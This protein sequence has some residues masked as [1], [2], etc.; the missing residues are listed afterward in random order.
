MGTV[1]FSVI[2]EHLHLL[3]ATTEMRRGATN[4]L[5]WLV[6]SAVTQISIGQRPRSRN[7]GAAVVDWGVTSVNTSHYPANER[8]GKRLELLAL[9]QHRNN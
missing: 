5:F 8:C 4:K 2:L 7:W 1:Y 9:E 3:P 6:K